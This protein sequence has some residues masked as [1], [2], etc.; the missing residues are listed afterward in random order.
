MDI[1]VKIIELCGCGFSKW[2]CSGLFINMVILEIFCLAEK[3]R[4]LVPGEKNLKVIFKE[5]HTKDNGYQENI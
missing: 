2:F 5:G 3:V 1:F 4:I